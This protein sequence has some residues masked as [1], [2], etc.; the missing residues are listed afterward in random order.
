VI[1]ERQRKR[2]H[3]RGAQRKPHHDNTL[4]LQELNDAGYGPVA[5]QQ[6]RRRSIVTAAVAGLAAAHP[7]TAQGVRPRCLIATMVTGAHRE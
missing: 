4:L 5:G 3:I 1:G 6:T 2:I 7:I